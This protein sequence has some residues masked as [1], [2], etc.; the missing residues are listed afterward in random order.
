MVG[1][2][3]GMKPAQ[4][5][6]LKLEFDNDILHHNIVKL[7]IGPPLRKELKAIA[8]RKMDQ[9]H[10]HTACMWVTCTNNVKTH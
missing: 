5:L 8:A 7:L 6:C 10:K 9:F 1:H 3:D 4:L 2:S